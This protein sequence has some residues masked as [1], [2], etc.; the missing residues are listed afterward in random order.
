MAILIEGTKPF[1]VRTGCGHIVIRRM[2]E[3][4]AGVPFTPETVLEAPNGRPCDD[5]ALAT[6]KSKGCVYR[7]PAYKSRDYEA[8]NEVAVV[9]LEA[10]GVDWRQA[11]VSILEGL[12]ML[13]RRGDR[14][15]YGYL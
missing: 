11:D 4:T 1:Q 3:A 7:N 8:T 5:C 6:A 12:T 14:E 2:R 15:V 9:C 13:Y 10:P